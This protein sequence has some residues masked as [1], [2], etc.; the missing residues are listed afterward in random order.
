MPLQTI[1]IPNTSLS[2][3]NASVDKLLKLAN[4]DAALLYL[5][6]LRCGGEY[7]PAAAQRL[8]HRSR[9]ELDTA[10]AQL[11]ELGLVSG[12]LLPVTDPP[13]PQPD[14]APAYSSADIVSELQDPGSSFSALLEEVESVLGRKLPTSQTAILLELYD[15]VGLPSEVLLTLVSW[16]QGRNQ[17]KYGPGKR[18]SM[19]MVKRVGYQWKEHGYDTL[20]AAD[21][22]IRSCDLRESQVGAM[23]AACGIFGRAPLAT[24]GKYL[25]QWLDWRFPPESIAVAY[26]I[27]MTNL[28]KM[29]WQYCNGIVRKWHEKNLHTLEEVRS[30]RKEATPAAPQKRQPAAAP[31]TPQD[32]QEDQAQLRRLLHR[33]NED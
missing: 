12:A 8:L 13:A 22:Y 7:D 17:K 1:Q 32:S 18:L 3:D 29:N 15:H 20:E 24:E 19:S 2:L 21:E 31:V 23:L 26:D 30:E 28:G 5:Y 11:Q 33:L 6:L 25:S 16:L 14:H 4:G 9:A 10:M 27:T